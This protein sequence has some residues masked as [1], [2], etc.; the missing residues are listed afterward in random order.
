GTY[1]W[2]GLLWAQD[3]CLHVLFHLPRFLGRLFY[4]RRLSFGFLLATGAAVG[5]GQVV[6]RRRIFRL[7][8]DGLFERLDRFF[9]FAVGDQRAP[10]ADVGVGEG[11]VQPRRLGEMVGGLRP[12]ARLSRHLAEHVFG[13]GVA[14]IDLQLFFELASRLVADGRRQVVFRQRKQ[15]SSQTVMYARQVGGLRQD[16]PILRRR[17]IP[18]F[19]RL[20]SLGV[21][22]SHL[23]RTGGVDQ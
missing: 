16:G 7:K 22:Q 6:M 12:V 21:E 17:F 5:D 1:L 15:Q 10:Q 19:L 2:F 13:A 14:R 9:E 20:Q 18:V 3:A 23:I 11:R 8:F 4:G